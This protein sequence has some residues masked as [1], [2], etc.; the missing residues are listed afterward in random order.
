[1]CPHNIQVQKLLHVCIYIKCSFVLELDD[2]DASTRGKRSTRQA[3]LFAVNLLG[4][5][6]DATTSTT[7]IAAA[8]VCQAIPP[9]LPLLL[10]A[11]ISLQVL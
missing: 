3:H 5:L 10:L 2:D 11:L 4:Y 6:D 9:R 1:M 8:T 7:T